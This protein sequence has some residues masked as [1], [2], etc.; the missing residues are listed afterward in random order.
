[1][2]NNWLETAKHE[3][4]QLNDDHQKVLQ[5]FREQQAEMDAW[6]KAGT[7]GEMHNWP[8]RGVGTWD[9]VVKMMMPGVRSP[10]TAKMPPIDVKPRQMRSTR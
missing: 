3:L 9:A 4:V 6:M 5:M 2:K 7:P 8:A 10:C 1:M